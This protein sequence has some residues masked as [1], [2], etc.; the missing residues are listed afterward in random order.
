MQNTITLDMQ[1]NVL[2]NSERMNFMMINNGRH[3]EDVIGSKAA[4]W[5]FLGNA[6]DAIEFTEECLE[7]GVQAVLE[8]SER[9][10]N[11]SGYVV[12]CSDA[13]ETFM[14]ILYKMF[15]HYS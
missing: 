11:T 1:K 3:M 6:H 15:P 8:V 14:R 10:G 2:K 9:Y 12:Y 13:G 4:E 7:Y 5:N